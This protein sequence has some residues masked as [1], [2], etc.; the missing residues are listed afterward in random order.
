MLYLLTLAKY[1]RKNSSRN[2]GWETNFPRREI[3][4]VA[5][6]RTFAY[7]VHYSRTLGVLREI[8]LQFR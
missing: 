2:C 6:I 3:M 7:T 1:P 8:I 5:L 4:N